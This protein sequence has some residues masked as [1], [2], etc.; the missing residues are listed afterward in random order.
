MRVE[1]RLNEVPANTDAGI[2]REDLERTPELAYLVVELMD[3]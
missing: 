3:A 2:D 1:C